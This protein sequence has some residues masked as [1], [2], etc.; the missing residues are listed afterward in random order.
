MNGLAEKEY[1]P[2]LGIIPVGTTND[3]ARALQIPRDIVGAAEII[4]K[5]DS[6]PIDI[7]RFND[8]YFINIAGGGRLTELTYEFL[9]N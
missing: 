1:R 6:I 5:G 4:A 3:F 9:V 8:K 7:G 2:K